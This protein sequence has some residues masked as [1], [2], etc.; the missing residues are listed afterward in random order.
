[1]AHVKCDVSDVSA[2]REAAAI[3]TRLHGAPTVLAAN[4]G[5]VRGRN[6]LDATDD[7]FRLTFGVN[8]MG[9][10]WYPEA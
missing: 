6:I 8:V 1:M 4:A 3:F 9:L 2:V 5:I 7:D 10:L